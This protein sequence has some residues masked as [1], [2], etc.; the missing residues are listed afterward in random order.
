MM[1]VQLVIKAE[2]SI[3]LQHILATGVDTPVNATDAYF[4]R[5]K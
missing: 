4:P 1:A 3:A 2:K 5:G